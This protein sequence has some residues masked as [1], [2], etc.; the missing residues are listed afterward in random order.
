MPLRVLAPR[1]RETWVPHHD[2]LPFAAIPEL[3]FM[4]SARRPLRESAGTRR[5]SVVPMLWLNKLQVKLGTPE[6][7]ARTIRELGATRDPRALAPLLEVAQ[8][9]EARVRQATMEALGNL[10]D[11]RAIP[12]LMTGLRDSQD[13]V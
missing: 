5:G 13:Y 3:F 11:Q 10:G 2:L 9:K 6:T 12:P 7:R 4:D 1:T 8:D